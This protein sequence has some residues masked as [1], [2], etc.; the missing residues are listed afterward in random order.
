[1]KYV[2]LIL[3][4]IYTG[5]STP[6]AAPP[7]TNGA[8]P[9]IRCTEHPLPKFSLA[10]DQSPS[11]QAQVALC[12]C[13]WSRLSDQDRAVAERLSRREDSVVDTSS[14]E[15]FAIRFGEAIGSCSVSAR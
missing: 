4:V 2:V 1:M 5:C 10:A 14:T 15:S 6:A 11:E 3:S 9:M 12:G 8:L 7:A 13:I